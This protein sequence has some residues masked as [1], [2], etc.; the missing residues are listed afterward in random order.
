MALTKENLNM[1][2]E[3]ERDM[4]AKAEQAI[5]DCADRIAI[6]EAELAALP[7]EPVRLRAEGSDRDIFILGG[8]DE[9][10]FG[11]SIG[12]IDKDDCARHNIDP[13]AL[14]AYICRYGQPDPRDAQLAAADALIQAARKYTAYWEGTGF[15]CGAQEGCEVM[16]ALRAFDAGREVEQ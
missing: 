15:R 7:K 3:R 1:L 16:N 11:L 14:A 5:S 4:V 2:I 10:G 13:D 9:V 8:D 12:C 6:Y